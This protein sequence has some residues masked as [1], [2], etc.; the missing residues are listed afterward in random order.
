[1]LSKYG[2]FSKSWENEGGVPKQVQPFPYGLSNARVKEIAVEEWSKV[3]EAN[4]IWIVSAESMG[5]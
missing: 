1:M 2:D 5:T 3:M 4:A